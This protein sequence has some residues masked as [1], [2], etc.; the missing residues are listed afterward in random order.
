MW[1]RMGRIN[2]ARIRCWVSGAPD[3]TEKSGIPD[4]R[5]PPIRGSGHR[6][7]LSFPQI[8][9]KLCPDSRTTRKSG[10]PDTAPVRGSG[11]R[12]WLQNRQKLCECCVGPFVRDAGLCYRLR[13]HLRTVGV[14]TGASAESC[15]GPE[16]GFEND[17]LVE[18]EDI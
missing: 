18:G 3:N 8:P 10:A 5:L 14:K 12:P 15:V 17:P 1:T 6:I 2:S 11:Q 4:T 13:T 16:A 7:L 9:V